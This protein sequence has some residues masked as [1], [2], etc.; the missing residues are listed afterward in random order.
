MRI[1]WA[2]ALA[3]AI[4]MPSL[5]FGGEAGGEKAKR[6]ICKEITRTG[7]HLPPTRVCKTAAEWEEQAVRAGIAGGPRHRSGDK[8][9]EAR[10]PLPTIQ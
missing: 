7:S 1:V 3:A 9:L 5:A 2:V 4:S 10:A 6:K 8:V